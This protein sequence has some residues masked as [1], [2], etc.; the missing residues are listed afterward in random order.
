MDNESGE[1]DLKTNT[2]VTTAGSHQRVFP[3][4]PVYDSGEEERVD[5]ARGG[6]GVME[7]LEDSVDSLRTSSGLEPT[8]Q[9]RSPLYTLFYQQFLVRTFVGFGSCMFAILGSGTGPRAPPPAA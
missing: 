5:G 6:E 7:Q 1:A 3:S 4:L 2:D 8:L 9:L